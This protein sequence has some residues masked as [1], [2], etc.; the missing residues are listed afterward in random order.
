[1]EE[2]RMKEVPSRSVRAASEFKDLE[3]FFKTTDEDVETFLDVLKGH[4]GTPGG[5]GLDITRKLMA[6][7]PDKVSA[8]NRLKS[9]L[10]GFVRLF[11]GWHND[12][13]VWHIEHASIRRPWK[14]PLDRVIYIIAK[15]MHSCLPDIEVTIWPP[16]LDWELKTI[17]FKALN[18]RQE[19][20]FNEDIIE[21]INNRLFEALNKVV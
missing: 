6:G 20:S 18:L 9:S 14:I 15:T 21:Q 11:H 8:P 4:M 10:S 17:T 3:S 12:D 5:Q 7:K 13:Y 16:Q 2:G 1:V 19:W